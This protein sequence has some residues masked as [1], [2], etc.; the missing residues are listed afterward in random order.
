[1]PCN[2]ACGVVCGWGGGGGG[3][4]GRTWSACAVVRPLARTRVQHVVLGG[5]PF[6]KVAAVAG[7]QPHAVGILL[8]RAQQGG[9]GGRRA[10]ALGR[11]WR[12]T[13]GPAQWRTRVLL[14]PVWRACLEDLEQRRV[15]APRQPNDIPI[16][17]PLILHAAGARGGGRHEHRAGRGVCGAPHGRERG[18]KAPHLRIRALHARLGLAELVCC[19]RAR[20]H[21]R[22]GRHTKGQC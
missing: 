11:R 9:R 15:D 5:L 3:A 10:H 18:G 19:V 13:S 1:M 8:L 7:Q 4:G 14:S 17:W 20:A 21:K 12:H 16:A 2:A 22:G 6:L